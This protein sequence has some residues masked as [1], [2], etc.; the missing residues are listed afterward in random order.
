MF[1]LPTMCH[2]DKS[3]AQKTGESRI[4]FAVSSAVTEGHT[5]YFRTS[6]VKP[7]LSASQHPGLIR[8]QTR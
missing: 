1:L 7:F 4:P 8:L 6:P 2:T 5:A 3:P